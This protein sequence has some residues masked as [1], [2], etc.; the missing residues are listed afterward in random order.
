M[1]LPLEKGCTPVKAGAQL[2]DVRGSID[3]ANNWTP[4]FVGERRL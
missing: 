4:A 3:P 1:I 2:G